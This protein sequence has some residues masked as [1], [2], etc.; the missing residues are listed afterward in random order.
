MFFDTRLAERV[1]TARVSK[2]N[3]TSH[4]A[5]PPVRAVAKATTSV[6]LAVARN[7]GQLRTYTYKKQL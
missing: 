4:K 3:A 2:L 6:L 7:V 5:R 1:L